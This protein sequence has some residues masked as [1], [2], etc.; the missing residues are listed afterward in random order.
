MQR[1]KA[2]SELLTSD[3]LCFRSAFIVRAVV[4]TSSNACLIAGSISAPPVV[5]GRAHGWSTEPSLPILAVRVA[6]AAN[7]WDVDVE[8]WWPWRRP[9]APDE[10]AATLATD[11][12]V[13]IITGRF[14]TPLFLLLPLLLLLLRLLVT[15]SV[16]PI[17]PSWSWA[18]GEIVATLSSHSSHTHRRRRRC[19]RPSP[20]AVS[21]SAAAAAAAAVASA[22][23]PVIGVV[24]F[25]L[26]SLIHI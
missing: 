21:V 15:R 1:Q 2:T 23:V 10:A 20:A 18:E 6:S 12:D 24:Q 17:A 13:G 14:V 8:V 25:L 3:L 19:D 9:V 5:V 7:L 4:C 22:P 11:N 16:L 26:L